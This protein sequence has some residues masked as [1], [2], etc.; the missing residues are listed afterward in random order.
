VTASSRGA[1]LV[2][3]AVAAAPV[4]AEERVRIAVAI[5]AARASI[6]GDRLAVTALHDGATAARVAGDRAEVSIEGDAILVNG[7]RVD[8]AGAVFTSEGHVRA[9][10][11]PLEGEVEVRRGP[12]GLLVINALPLETYV[13]AVTASEMPAQFPLEALKAQAVAA[14]TFAVFKK[15]D[16]VAEG[17]AWHLGATVLHQVYRGARVDPRARAA[18]EATAGQVLVF[19]HQVIEAYFHSTCGGRT[20]RGADALGRDQ[21]YLRSVPCEHCRDSPR[22][23]WTVRVDAE[24][25]A[26]VAGLPGRIESV[27][28]ADRTSSGRARRVELAS[29]GRRVGVG[30][31]DLRQRLGFERLPSLWFD[32]RV[33]GRTVEFDGRGAGHGAGLCQW[34]AAGAAREGQDYRAILAHYYP[35][36]ELIRMY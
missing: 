4:R 35:G 6:A 20:E 34:G 22:A 10:G 33:R 1:L 26:R 15:L 36:A 28:V 7:S 32:V 24:E 3:L 11:M 19:E 25:L 27:R 23:R 8:G 18:A 21:P 31:V 13:A 14:R 30:A 2:A 5:G 29:G 9:A 16:A 17:R 12:D